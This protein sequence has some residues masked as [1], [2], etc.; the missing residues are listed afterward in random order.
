MNISVALLPRDLDQSAV[1]SHAVIVFDVLRATTTITAALAG[2]V[3]EVRAFA[4]LESTRQAAAAFIGPKLLCGEYRCLP[5]DGFDLGNS[6]L[7][8]ETTRYAGRTMF[9]STTNGTR[10]FIAARTAKLLLAGAL[11]NAASVARLLVRANLNVTLC[12][13]GTE[14]QLSIEDLLG[15]GSVIHELSQLVPIALSSDSAILALGHFRERRDRLQETLF[16]T[17]AGRNIRAVKLDADIDYCASLNR[18]NVVG[19][20]NASGS[21]FLT[22]Q[23]A[24]SRLTC[25]RRIP[26]IDHSRSWLGH[27]RGGFLSRQYAR[28]SVVITGIGVVSP[29]GIGAEAYAAA[30]RDGISGI[31]APHDLDLQDLRTSAV[32]QVCGFDVA[33]VIGNIDARRVPRMVAP[34]RTGFARGV[35]RRRTTY[36]ALKTL[37]LRDRLVSCSGRAAGV[38]RLLKKPIA[39]GF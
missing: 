5:P 7:A 22:L 8:F 17:Q 25:F 13:A 27:V 3:R 12:C 32:G 2:Q 36:C 4:D 35:G 23:S 10:A 18:L 20:V 31:R 15:A 1:R 6:P 34:A 9:L 29:N 19:V 33:S 24:A 37:M 16:D 39:N 38:S 21:D 28:R 14:G 11:V 30:C 26:S